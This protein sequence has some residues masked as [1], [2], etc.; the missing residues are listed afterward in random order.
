M[1]TGKSQALCP[2]AFSRWQS[3]DDAQFSKQMFRAKGG[4]RFWSLSTDKLP[5]FFRSDAEASAGAGRDRVSRGTVVSILK[6]Y[7]FNLFSITL[8]IAIWQRAQ[9][10]LKKTSLSLFEVGR[11]APLPVSRTNRS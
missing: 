5:D 9:K 8:R 11:R 4:Q 1:R 3:V 2:Y 10:S 6:K 7:R